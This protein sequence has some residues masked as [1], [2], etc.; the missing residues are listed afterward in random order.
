LAFTVA[1]FDG[2]MRLGYRMSAS[3]KRAYLHLWS[4]VG[5][6]LGITEAGRLTDL[7]VAKRL[8]RRLEVSL[9]ETSPWGK[10]LMKTLLDDMSARMPG[11]LR[12]LP[13]AL[14][15]RLA[16]H[17]VADVL[18]VPHSRLAPAVAVVVSFE[19]LVSRATIGRW[20]LRLPSKLLGRALIGHSIAE[21]AGVAE[22][23]YL[24]PD[25][26]LELERS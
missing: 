16:G 14:V 1:A 6:H 12:S 25:Q 7:A 5:H 26:W 24:W 17:E 18:D 3:D 9:Q 10:E 13:A 19:R 23:A 15:R 20:T 2:I 4:V 8:T 21:G 22:P 11:P